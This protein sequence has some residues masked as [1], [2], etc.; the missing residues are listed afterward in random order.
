MNIDPDRLI[1]ITDL[2]RKTSKVVNE[3]ADTDETY[4]V[5]KDNKLTAALVSYE[6]F[7]GMTDRLDALARRSQELVGA[8][9]H[10]LDSGAPI[11][12]YSVAGVPR[13]PN[14]LDADA[15]VQRHWLRNDR[16]TTAHAPIGV[17]HKKFTTQLDLTGS[18]GPHSAVF[19]GTPEARFEVLVAMLSCL[20]S[21]YS[22]EDLTF[23]LA[24]YTGD[25]TEAPFYEHHFGAAGLPHTALRTA[26]P[27]C[28]EL[29]DALTAE[30]EAR[31]TILRQHP[32]DYRQR[33]RDVDYH[34][35]AIPF[36]VVVLATSDSVPLPKELVDGVTT[37]A[38]IG[39][40]LGIHLLISADSPGSLEP[41]LKAQIATFFSIDSDKEE[42]A[43]GGI[44][45]TRTSIPDGQVVDIRIATCSTPVLESGQTESQSLRLAGVIRS[46]AGGRTGALV[47]EKA[48][49]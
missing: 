41:V 25:P 32:G 43:G 13:S 21:R 4:L 31:R 8:P 6:R 38:R 46:A 36:L 44:A 24:D 17:D 18:S 39:R 26:D 48:S 35:P 45:V 33:R 49:D 14:F 30:I 3:V 20:A 23:A 9:V 5:L 37:L 42:G 1:S 47:S 27:S 28:P 10:Q 40:D 15:Y 16:S 11:E 34:L 29:L 12:L 19:G 22:P 7:R 2:A